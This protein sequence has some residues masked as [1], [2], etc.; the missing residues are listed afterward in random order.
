MH[1]HNP[2]NMSPFLFLPGQ[3][4]L[5]HLDYNQCSA[6]FVFEL[7]LISLEITGPVVLH[8]SLI[9]SGVHKLR[10]LYDHIPGLHI[11]KFQIL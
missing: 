5:T 10:D 4:T 8:A 7:H 6:A 1:G 9:P 11:T 3:I 2:V